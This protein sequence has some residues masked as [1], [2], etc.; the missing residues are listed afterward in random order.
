MAWDDSK[1][2]GGA[3]DCSYV[4]LTHG[5]AA[6]VRRLRRARQ[7]LPFVRRLDSN[8]SHSFFAAAL[9]RS[10]S[11]RP[12]MSTSTQRSTTLPFESR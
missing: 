4:R 11:V 5:S 1:W 3:P 6:G 12:S 7:L 10:R 2:V 9:A 8:A